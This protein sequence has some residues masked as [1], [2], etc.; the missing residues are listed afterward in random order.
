M[1]K[2]T[3]AILIGLA[4]LVAGCGPSQVPPPAPVKKTTPAENTATSTG[5]PKGKPYTEEYRAAT[6][7]ALTAWAAYIKNKSKENY[8]A[9]GTKFYTA[10]KYR[11]MHVRNGHSSE[12]LH[13]YTELNRDYKDWKST[14]GPIG[15][16]DDAAYKA[17]KAEYDKVQQGE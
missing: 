11:S 16:E 2:L 7:E 5:K 8:A 9:C 17:A 13:K 4:T 12:G 6:N 15:W 1:A 10:L 3:A 14:I